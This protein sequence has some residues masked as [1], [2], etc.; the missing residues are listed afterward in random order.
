MSGKNWWLLLLHLYPHHLRLQ[1]LPDL[2]RWCSTTVKQLWKTRH[3]NWS[4]WNI[5]PSGLPSVSQAISSAF[6]VSLLSDEN[7]IIHPTCF[8][9]NSSSTTARYVHRLSV[10]IYVTS[11]HHTWLCHN[12]LPFRIVRDSNMFMTDMPRPGSRLLATNQSQLFL[13]LPV[14]QRPIW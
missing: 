9:A 6:I 11:P 8:L 7:D 12:E 5:P 10:Q 1:S 13:S 3:Q 2:A 14:S 4:L